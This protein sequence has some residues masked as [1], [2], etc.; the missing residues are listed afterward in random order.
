MVTTDLQEVIRERGR[1]TCHLWLTLENKFL[2][3]RETCTLHLDAA[4]HNFVQGDLSVT[5]YCRKLKG[6]ADALAD[7]R[8]PVDD[9]ILVL[10]ILRGLNQCFE[11]LGAIIRRSSLFPNFLKV[12]DGL[13]LEEIH[14]DTVGSSTAPTA[15]YTNTAPP[16]PKPQLSTSSQPPNSNNWNKNNNRHTSGN[17]CGND[18]KNNS[19][20]G[21]R[22][23]NSGNTT[24]AH[25]GL[26]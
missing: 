2:G 1:P 6:M 24:V 3:N 4:F 15:L 26:H 18:G 23:G 19:S 8:S 14:L 12:C 13:L 11:H 7:L 5:E 21:G 25:R 17:D 20:S 10:D 22:G 9:R 16:A